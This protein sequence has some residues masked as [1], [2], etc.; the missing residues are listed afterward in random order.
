LLYFRKAFKVSVE[1]CEGKEG[2]EYLREDGWIILKMV[3]H[4]MGKC[5]IM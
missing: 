3:L 4:M 2:L 1:N 5:E